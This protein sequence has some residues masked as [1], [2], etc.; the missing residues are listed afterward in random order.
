MADQKILLVEGTDDEHVMKHICGNRDIPRLDEVV[1]HG[2]YKN[3]L[4]SFPTK[5][6]FAETGDVVGVV[7]DADTD[8]DAR[9]QAVRDRFI[10]V[11]YA[12][13]PDAP[14]PNGTILE[15]VF[16]PLVNLALPRAGVWIMPD[17]RTKGILEDFLRFMVPQPNAVL[18]H[19]AASVDSIPEKYFKKKDRSK[20]LIHTWLA[21]QKK[22]GKPYGTAIKA[23]FLD[24]G[25]P[26]ADVLASWLKRL[27]FP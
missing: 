22:P 19:A 8:L 25:V 7:I 26:Q 27:F 18:D 1:P 9:W 6:Q 20:A 5:L 10:E 17:N 2:N 13:V 15:P 4:K 11:G 23:R 3:L 14:D 12:D 21:W 24:P 16:K